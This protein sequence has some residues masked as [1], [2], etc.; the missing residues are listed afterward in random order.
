MRV[1]FTNNLCAEQ[2][3]LDSM[4]ARHLHTFNIH[5]EIVAEIMA[6]PNSPDHIRDMVDFYCERAAPQ[7]RWVRMCR[8]SSS[9]ALWLLS[10]W[11]RAGQG[12]RAG[13]GIDHAATGDRMG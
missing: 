7:P 11:R 9:I 1:K 12:G 3:S 6:I 5:G 13:P 2:P 4:Y 8:M 10:G